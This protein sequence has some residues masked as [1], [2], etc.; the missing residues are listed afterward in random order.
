MLHHSSN[1]NVFEQ[2]VL[3]ELPTDVIFCSKWHLREIDKNGHSRKPGHYDVGNRGKNACDGKNDGGKKFALS[4][5]AAV[6]IQEGIVIL[7]KLYKFAI[8]QTVLDW[9]KISKN[10]IEQAFSYFFWRFYLQ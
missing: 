10:F 7:T 5:S 6:T 1:C 9:Q 4:W 2:S 8:L 3:R